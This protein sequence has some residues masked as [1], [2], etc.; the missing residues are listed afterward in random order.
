MMLCFKC[1]ISTHRLN[2]VKGK[3]STKADIMFIG[4]NPG[5]YEDKKGIPFIGESG[6][7]LDKYL[8][9]INLT[10]DDIYVTNIIKCKTPG[11]RSP[12]KT[13]IN[14]CSVYLRQEIKDI[15]PKIIILLGSIAITRFFPSITHIKPIIGKWI[16]ANNVYFL[17]TY[18]PSYILRNNITD[19]LYE[20]QFR[21]LA[22]LY[23]NLNPFYD[24][25]Y[26]E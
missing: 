9:S 2:I 3:G 5:Y 24:Y 14:N 4:Q 21:Q 1:D 18:H 23:K 16:Y 15:K 17:L 19:R 8:K 12:S 10:L 13:E 26:N 22:K 11:N 25:E 6:K 7:L 20:K